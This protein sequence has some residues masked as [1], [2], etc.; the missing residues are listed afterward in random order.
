[1]NCK[2]DLIRVCFMILKMRFSPW[3]KRCVMNHS[4]L[5]L[6]FITLLLRLVTNPVTDHPRA[7]MVKTWRINCKTPCITTCYSMSLNRNWWTIHT[8]YKTYKCPQL[9]TIVDLFFGRF[10]TDT[11]INILPL[12]HCHWHIMSNGS[13]VKERGKIK[14]KFCRYMLLKRWD[15]L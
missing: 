11:S 6:C 7:Y 10:Q 3:K 4:F 2:F 1:M 12:S 5:I 15:Q 9:E 14:L 13:V 8:A